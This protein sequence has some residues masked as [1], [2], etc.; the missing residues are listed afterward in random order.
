MNADY[1]TDYFVALA[2]NVK[3]DSFVALATKINHANK[4]ILIYQHITNKPST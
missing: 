3:Y 4:R 2:S 1:F